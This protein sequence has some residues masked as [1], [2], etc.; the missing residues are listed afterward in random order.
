MWPR[1]V[2]KLTFFVAG[3]FFAG[4]RVDVRDFF[5]GG[6]SSSPEVLPVAAFARFLA[7]GRAFPFL[8]GVASTSSSSSSSSPSSSELDF[9]AFRPRFRGGLGSGE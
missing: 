4:A 2:F 5:A 6:S 3:G 1:T 9:A 8:T 7:A